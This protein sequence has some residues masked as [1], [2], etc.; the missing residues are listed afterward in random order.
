MSAIKAAAAAA[1]AAA[2]AAEVPELAGKIEVTDAP[3][4]QAA[5]YPAAAIEMGRFTFEAGTMDVV[6]DASG[7]PVMNGVDALAEGGVVR[8]S[9]RIWLATRLPP[10]REQL[11][12]AIQ[13]AFIA[14]DLAPGR[15]AVT[16]SNVQVGDFATGV[17]WPLAFFCEDSEWNEE[18]VFSEKRWVFLTIEVDL[19]ILVLLKNVP[20]V[21]TLIA[22]ITTDLATTVDD[23]SD[24]A[25]LIGLDQ[26]RV[27][28]DGTSSPY[29]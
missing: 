12:E 5:Q 16:L 25:T 27:S 7:A 3:P 4:S 18:L 19:P 23:P 17:D 8:G 20:K 26:V 2:I 22:Q 1:L 13:R 29:P 15:L 28:A 24:V 21:T 9:L 11:E 6:D 14:D 10:Q